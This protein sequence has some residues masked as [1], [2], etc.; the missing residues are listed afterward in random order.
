VTISVVSTGA[1]SAER[2][3]LVSTTSCFFVESRS[4]RSAR[5]LS[6]AKS[7]GA[8]VETTEGPHAIALG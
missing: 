6:R 8:S 7:R 1:R 3:D 4:L 2:R 5:R